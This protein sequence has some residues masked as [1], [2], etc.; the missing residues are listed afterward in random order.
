[1][2][3]PA[4][5]KLTSHSRR[6]QTGLNLIEVMFVAFIISLLAIVALP[7]YQ[8]Y[9]VRAKVTGGIAF[10]P[11]V[12]LRVM[13][14]FLAQGTLPTLYS[15]LGLDVNDFSKGDVV[16]ES[17]DIV[18]DPKTGTIEIVFDKLELP[19]VGDDNTVLFLP[20][21][22]N[23]TLEWDCTQGTMVSRFRPSSCR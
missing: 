1:V 3:T 5:Q 23:G 9:T 14:Y 15:Q 8:D 7:V 6:R 19:A 18:N 2:N 17:L 12:K 21:P 13:E 22:T 16:L 10:V 11:P 20:T 4:D